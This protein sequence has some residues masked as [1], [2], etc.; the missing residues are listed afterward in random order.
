MRLSGFFTKKVDPEDSEVRSAADKVWE[1]RALN[2]PEILGSEKRILASG[3]VQARDPQ[4]NEWE[5]V[6]RI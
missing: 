4:T 6:G 3:E 2:R 5:T 1:L